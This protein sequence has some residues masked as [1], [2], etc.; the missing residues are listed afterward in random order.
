VLRRREAPAAAGTSVP[1]GQPVANWAFGPVGGDQVRKLPG[2]L[3]KLPRREDDEA[4]EEGIGRVLALSDGVFAIALTLLIIDIAVPATTSNAGLPRALLALWPRYLAYLVSFVVIAR[5]WGTHR[6]AF[7]LIAR[8]DAALVWLNLLLLLFVAFLPFPTAVLGQHF[9]SPAAA[10]L[11][12]TSVTLASIAAMA[13]WWYASGRGGL[14]RSG[15]RRGQVR[16][17]RARSLSASVFFALTLPIAV[18]APYVAEIVWIL[19]FPLPGWYLSGSLL[20]TT[21]SLVSAGMQ[22]VARHASSAITKSRCWPL[23]RLD[24]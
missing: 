11:Y 9:G 22:T 18:F 12:A 21:N 19:V 23:C 14:L 17:L 7:R 5:F 3:W 6:L 16:A 8:D 10:V 24:Y 1:P 15:V 2:G 20:R 4:A 13:Y